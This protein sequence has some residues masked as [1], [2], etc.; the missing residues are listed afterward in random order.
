MRSCAHY[1]KVRKTETETETE[2]DRD[3]QTDRQTERD[4]FSYL[5]ETRNEEFELHRASI[6]TELHFLYTAETTNLNEL[7]SPDIK[8]QMGLG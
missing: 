6:T 5:E 8:D 7:F 1:L 4:Y 2:R 3:R